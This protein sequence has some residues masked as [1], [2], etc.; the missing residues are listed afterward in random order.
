MKFESGNGFGK[1]DR[2][3]IEGDRVRVVSDDGRTLFTIT[4]TRT[5]IEING[6]SGRI[7]DKVY[8]APLL[9]IP[10]ASNEIVI[11]LTEWK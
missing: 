10:R 11:E 7:G 2:Q 6:G 8:L 9:I 1:H 5:G 3:D 4:M